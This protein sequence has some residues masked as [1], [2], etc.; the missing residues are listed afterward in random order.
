MAKVNRKIIME[1]LDVAADRL[2]AKVEEI[3]A[4]GDAHEVVVTDGNGKV[5]LKVSLTKGMAVGA[6]A[7]LGAPII[8]LLGCIAALATNHTVEVRRKP[9]PK[10]K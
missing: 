1:K 5:N 7:T 8:T 3:V 6:V 2:V 10:K 4:K 9:E